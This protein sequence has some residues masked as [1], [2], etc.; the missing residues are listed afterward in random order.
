MPARIRLQRRGK[1]GQ[2]FYHIVI[3]D[4]RAPRDGRFIEKIG[5]YNPLTKPATIEINFEKALDWMNK[6]AQPTDTVRAI[7]TYKGV[8][9]KRHLMKGVAKGA[10]TQEEAETKFQQWIQEKDAR[11]SRK[12]NEHQQ[13]LKDTRKKNLE[14]ET[15]VNEA[16][17]Q[18]LAKKQSEALARMK[19]EEPAGEPE[20]QA[21]NTQAETPAAE[22][23]Q[24]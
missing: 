20:A 12:R 24:E 22:P 8:N 23:A 21:E 15:K 16:K 4:G 14:Y 3:A 19:A 2:A 9:Y 11:I 17:A 5:I 1:K 7:L 18:A 10:M 13:N 6:G